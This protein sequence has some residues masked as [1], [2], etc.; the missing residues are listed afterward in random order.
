[1]RDD[2]QEMY[3][4]QV[5]PKDNQRLGFGY[6]I[7]CDSNETSL[8]EG[9]YLNNYPVGHMRSF[10]SLMNYFETKIDMSN[11]SQVEEIK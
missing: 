11:I 8:N 7:I 5:N 2:R 4:G 9:L 6:I 3:I 10:S 1:M